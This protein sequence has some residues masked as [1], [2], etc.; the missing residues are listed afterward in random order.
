MKFFQKKFTVFDKK[1]IDYIELEN[2]S[3]YKYFIEDE[4]FIYDYKIVAN[5]FINF[6]L[7][8]GLKNKY[9]K[10]L[11]FVV[12]NFN[13]FVIN[14]LH[15]ISNNYQNI[16]SLLGEM[17]FQ[18][19]FY[20]VVIEPML[21]MLEPP[22]YVKVIK[23]S[24]RVKK[25]TK[26]EFVIKIVYLKSDKRLNSSIRQL[27]H[28]TGTFNDSKFKIR[29]YKSFLLTFLDWNDSYLHKLKYSIFK[30][31]LKSPEKF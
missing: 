20:S 29:L 28:Y 8:K 25:K 5:N 3:I 24:K 14:N 9:K 6:F 22:F 21:W 1:T 16:N 12:Y 19:S 2:Y 13:Y 4:D 23:A 17:V 27:K 15:Y 11:S 10:F 26:K 30:K 18:K 31:F 7:K